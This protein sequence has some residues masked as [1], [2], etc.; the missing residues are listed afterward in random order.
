[1][2]KILIAFILL[3]A[4]L[5]ASCQPAELPDASDES[6]VPESPSETKALSNEPEDCEPA[7]I[8]DSTVM[9]RDLISDLNG[10][11]TGYTKTEINI[12]NIKGS[13]KVVDA[14][15][16]SGQASSWFEY[17]TEHLTYP[18]SYSSMPFVVNARDVIPEA[19]EDHAYIFIYFSSGVYSWYIN[20]C[21]RAEV[22]DG[23]LSVYF[24]VYYIPNGFDMAEKYGFAVLTVEKS[25]LSEFKDLYVGI[26]NTWTPKEQ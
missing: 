7:N 4:V 15:F 26:K 2:K 25:S 8:L 24:N 5:L 23:F 9:S 1:M 13:I 18:F 6:N 3:L 11:L 14:A 10:I 21:T 22:K 16:Y 17:N 20:D 12:S 19:D